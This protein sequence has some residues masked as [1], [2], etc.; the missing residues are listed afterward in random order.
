MKIPF[1]FVLQQELQKLRHKPYIAKECA[2]H[3][4]TKPLH[5]FD[6]ASRNTI[7]LTREHAVP[8]TVFDYHGLG[9]EV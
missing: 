2:D 3:S 7:E 6:Y 4:F 1:I 8:E 9:Y 5:P